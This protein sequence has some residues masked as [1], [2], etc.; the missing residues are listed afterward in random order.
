M[1]NT[2]KIKIMKV[3][4]TAIKVAPLALTTLTLV[5]GSLE[6]L[7]VRDKSPWTEG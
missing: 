4:T 2:R 6:P 7:N 1:K 3:A 5:S